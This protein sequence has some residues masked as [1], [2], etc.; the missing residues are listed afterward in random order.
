MKIKFLALVNVMFTAILHAQVGIGTENP[1]STLDVVGIPNEALSV[2]GIMA[3]RLTGMQLKAKDNVYTTDQ[4][5]AIV[6]VTSG[7][8][9]SDTTAKTINVTTEGY[10]YFD[11]IVWQK[12]AT[13]SSANSIWVRQNSDKDIALV[14]SLGKETE[15]YTQ[16]GHKI[17]DKDDVN[18]YVG[19]DSNGNYET[20]NSTN[21]NEYYL[22][23]MKSSDF[24][25]N[26][27]NNN[28]SITKF[29]RK[30][31]TIVDASDNTYD[32]KNYYH[33]YSLMQTTPDNTKDIPRL[34]TDVNTSEHGGQGLVNRLIGSMGTASVIN[35]SRAL[36][37]NGTL[38]SAI[39]SSS[40]DLTNLYGSMSNAS[41][42]GSGK[43]KL[44]V[45]AYNRVDNYIF[46]NT[47]PIEESIATYSSTL[48]NNKS[49]GHIDNLYGNKINNIASDNDVTN[50]FG[51]YITSN[52]PK[53]INN[54]GIFLD[55]I[56][57]GANK[58]SIYS[59]GGN[60]Y[61]K[62]NV[63]IGT[64]APSNALHV[65]TASDPLRLEG[66]Q[67][68]ASGNNILVAAADGVVKTISPTQMSTTPQYFYAPSIVLPTTSFGVSTA[69]TD[70]IFYNSS[71]DVYTVKLHTI[72]QKQFG[73]VGDVAGVNRTAI[74]S[75]SSSSLKTFTNTELDYFITY[76][77][78]SV[79]DPS[80]IT[81]STDG[82]LTY[83]V[84][85][86]AEISEKTYMN[87]VFKVK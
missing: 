10:Y 50:T 20:L 52:V 11:G 59:N 25:S 85:T 14:Y 68:G 80:T 2:D 47:S 78:N 76:F 74:R 4:K 84:I 22:R 15:T 9:V 79:F 70:D 1:K 39:F 43:L 27:T 63:G 56:T 77:D 38:S 32:G 31:L 65:K 51:T 28:I 26:N 71:T 69:N 58:W 55:N 19:K 64:N 41:T 83:K 44:V 60:S 61:F 82:V 67:T 8:L 62:D 3:P 34:Y 48:F 75:N 37:L 13:G 49:I 40:S 18:Y 57:T 45:G 7:L 23:K 24:V 81:L 73:L 6:Y 86:N 33:N 66:L 16:G 12:Y 53:T 54:Y 46:D 29:F 35:T 72:Y 17:V 5:G 36:E 87:I 42:R 30:D 21:G